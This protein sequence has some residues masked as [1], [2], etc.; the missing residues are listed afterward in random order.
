MHSHP[1]AT[2]SEEILV[3][4]IEANNGFVSGGNFTHLKLD[5]NVANTN[6]RYVTYHMSHIITMW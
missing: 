5:L 2:Q 4:P 3:Q 6:M 1:L